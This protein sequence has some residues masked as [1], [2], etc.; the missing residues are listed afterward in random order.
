MSELNFYLARDLDGVCRVW[1]KRPKWHESIGRWLSA[2]ET[3]DVIGFLYREADEWPDEKFPRGRTG[4]ARLIIDET[5]VITAPA[6][7]ANY[8]GGAIADS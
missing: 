5:S 1:K 3:F 6:P 4:I 7:D 2:T 8:A